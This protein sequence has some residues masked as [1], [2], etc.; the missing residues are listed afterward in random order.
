MGVGAITPRPV[1][2]PDGTIGVEQR[3]NLS[4]TIDHQ[5]IDGA[6]G[7]RFLRDL[8]AAIENIDVTV[9]A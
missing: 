3:L 8:V 6:D 4:L 5:V 1:V 2:A 7:A 9:L